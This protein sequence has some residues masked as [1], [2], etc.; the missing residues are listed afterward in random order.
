V[1]PKNVKKN[2]KSVTPLLPNDS[3]RCKR[4]GE[5]YVNNT[6]TSC[7]FHTGTYSDLKFRT[8]W[9]CC[10][11]PDKKFPGCT[12]SLH[13]EDELTSQFLAERPVDNDTKL[14]EPEIVHTPPVTKEVSGIE[15][16]TDKYIRKADGS[17]FYKH[18]VL[19][20]DTLRAIA[21][22]YSVNPN[23]LKKANRIFGM[24]DEIHLKDYLLIP[25][26]KTVSEEKIEFPSPSYDEIIQMFKYEF[27][28]SVEEAKYY[29][30]DA[31]WDIT[32]ARNLLSKDIEF[33]KKHPTAA[34]KVK[35]T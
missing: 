27:N 4:C 3:K 24:D 7:V 26:D 28:I 20:T 12:T 9:S 18:P 13:I 10:K 35:P 5:Y 2:K 11:Q 6:E 17:I 32:L 15:E 33:E 29:L 30:A 14:I 22:K 8:A 31:E 1:K 21:I 19:P 23:T 34:R 16:E 25:W